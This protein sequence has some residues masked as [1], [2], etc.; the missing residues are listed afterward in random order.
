[1]L[2]PSEIASTVL[3]GHVEMIYLSSLN[4]MNE[5]QIAL[6]EGDKIMWFAH[7]QINLN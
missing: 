7:N 2:N 3:A 6:Y 1:M 4:G 5:V